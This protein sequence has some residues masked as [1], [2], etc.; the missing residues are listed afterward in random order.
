MGN[1]FSVTSESEK[2]G[3]QVTSVKALSPGAASGLK[4][5]VDY[6]VKLNDI[7]V[8]HISPENVMEMV[9][10]IILVCGVVL[11]SVY[12]ILFE[13]STHTALSESAHDPGRLQHNNQV[14]ASSEVDSQ[15]QL[16]G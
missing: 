14:C 12:P 15:R 9:K 7:D 10:V 2:K 5:T 4:V 3:Y 8:A 16:A 1:K 13:T 11:V 6:I